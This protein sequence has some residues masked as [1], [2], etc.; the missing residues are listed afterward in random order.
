MEAEQPLIA[1]IIGIGDLK[2]AVDAHAIAPFL[3]HDR[4]VTFRQ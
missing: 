4:K 2:V 1:S 3:N